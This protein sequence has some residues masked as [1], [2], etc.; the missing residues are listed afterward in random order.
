MTGRD[1]LDNLNNIQNFVSKALQFQDE[2][3][4]KFDNYYSALDFLSLYSVLIYTTESRD[5]NKVLN[6][7]FFVKSILQKKGK[8]YAKDFLSNP[9]EN[10]E[11]ILFNN[12]CFLKLF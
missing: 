5:E 3:E 2:K 12:T 1:I 6:I 10:F 7:Y 11:L 8:I 4:L 9:K